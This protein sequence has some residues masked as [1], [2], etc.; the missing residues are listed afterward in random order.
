[1]VKSLFY[2]AMKRAECPKCHQPPGKYCTYPSGG[3]TKYP[4]KERLVVMEKQP[5][6]DLSEFQVRVWR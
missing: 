1:M 5:K 3:K 6:F 4:H 2:E